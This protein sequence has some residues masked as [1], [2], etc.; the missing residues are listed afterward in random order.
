MNNSSGEVHFTKWAFYEYR[1]TTTTPQ[2]WSHVRSRRDKITLNTTFSFC[3]ALHAVS[4]YWIPCFLSGMYEFI[5]F[6][7]VCTTRSFWDWAAWAGETWW[8][9]PVISCGEW[10]RRRSRYMELSSLSQEFIFRTYPICQHFSYSGCTVISRT[11]HVSLYTIT[12]T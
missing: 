8:T 5:Y 10:V 4:C 9:W 6:L 7:Y 12:Y 11:K 2:I 3:F 1:I